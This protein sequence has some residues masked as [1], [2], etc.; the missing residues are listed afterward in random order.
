[1]APL[2]QAD[3]VLFSHD[4]GAW[5]RTTRLRTPT[6]VAD[7]IRIS[8]ES[9]HIDAAV[10]SLQ[11]LGSTRRRGKLPITSAG[12]NGWLTY[13]ESDLVPYVGR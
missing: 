6:I 11:P 13:R 10:T 1:M 3:L 2:A 4:A 12:S 7:T 9:T 5:T 8:A